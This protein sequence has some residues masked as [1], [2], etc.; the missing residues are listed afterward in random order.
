V[1]MPWAH[2]AT[3]RPVGRRNLPDGRNLRIGDQAP[4][5]PRYCAATS[6]PVRVLR[7]LHPG[8]LE[9]DTADALTRQRPFQ[10]TR[11]GSLRRAK[12]S[13]ALQSPLEARRR[14]A[15]ARIG[16]RSLGEFPLEVVPLTASAMVEPEV[17]AGT[18]WWRG[19]ARSPPYPICSWRWPHANFGGTSH[20]HA[21][22]V[23]LTWRRSGNNSGRFDGAG[24]MRALP[25]GREAQP[26]LHLISRIICYLPSDA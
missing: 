11:S 22:R 1:P 6:P 7:P 24:P 21:A 3:N 15:L 23:S 10:T 13:T 17:M 16:S 2:F 14:L 25:K 26:P 20:G 18:G 12:R 4:S 8:R 9:A 5:R 19:S